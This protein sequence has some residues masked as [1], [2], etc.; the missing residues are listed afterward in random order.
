[1]T[2]RFLIALQFLTVFRLKNNLNETE[3]ELAASVG[4]Y[5]LVGLVL[6][7]LLAGCGA[8]LNALFP[9]AVTGILLVLIMALFT[10]GLHLD[11]LADTADGLL[12]HRGRTRSLE[13]M[14]DSAVGVFGA[15]ALIFILGLKTVLVVEII[16]RPYGL[17]ALAVFPLSS[18][19]AVSLTMCLSEYAR[20][21]GGLGRPF[22][23]LAGERELL[24]AGVSAALVSALLLPLQGLVVTLLVAMAALLVLRVWKKQIGGVT[25]DILGTVNELGECLALLLFTAWL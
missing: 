17:L 9:P 19:L 14:K 15:V 16:G 18:R 25:G 12:S 11:G 4:Y 24:L 8:A 20:E 23:T 5:P 21:E 13:I 3:E 10:R 1:M 7:G 6:G 22:I 2:R